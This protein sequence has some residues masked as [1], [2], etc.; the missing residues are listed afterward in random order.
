MNLTTCG[1]ED[2]VIMK[3]FADRGQDWVD[4]EAVVLRRGGELDWP[5]IERELK[6]L[7]EV[8]GGTPSWERLAGLRAAG[9]RVV[10]RKIVD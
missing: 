6:P 1:A 2:L 9:E 5:L 4:V 10:V 7:L 8:R 3:V